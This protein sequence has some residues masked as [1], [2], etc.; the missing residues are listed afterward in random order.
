V[1]AAAEGETEARAIVSGDVAAWQ[2]EVWSA[3]QVD[4]QGAV[5]T[6]AADRT[7]VLSADRG[8]ASA[9]DSAV[10]SISGGDA[11]REEP[12]EWVKTG[13]PDDAEAWEREEDWELLLAVLAEDEMR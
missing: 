1:N 10:W 6:T 4:Q 12:F 9:V 5:A 7:A 2:V 3:C 11:S 13:E 8:R